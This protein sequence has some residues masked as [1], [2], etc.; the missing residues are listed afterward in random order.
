MISWNQTGSNSILGG[1]QLSS[2]PNSLGPSS[3]T[4][5]S[6]SHSL[7]ETEISR[8]FLIFNRDNFNNFDAFTNRYILN[9]PKIM[10][11]RK[12]DKSVHFLLDMDTR[13][14]WFYIFCTD[15]NLD[16]SSKYRGV[17]RFYRGGGSSGRRW[18]VSKEN[19]CNWQ[20]VM[21]SDFCKVTMFTGWPSFM[22]IFV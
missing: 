4:S 5:S 17:C 22:W 13:Y 19:D 15:L 10:I 20:L 21:F 1:F 14:N 11:H 7:L 12:N 3:M 6:S 2:M 9:S 8:I 18:F 16:V